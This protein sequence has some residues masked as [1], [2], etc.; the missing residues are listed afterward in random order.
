VH[1]LYIHVHSKLGATTS[2]QLTRT[3]VDPASKAIVN[4]RKIVIDRQHAL[5]ARPTVFHH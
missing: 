3:V 2:Q 5:Y 1:V 4:T